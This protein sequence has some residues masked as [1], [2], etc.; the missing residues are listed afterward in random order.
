[1]EGR[2]FVMPRQKRSTYLSVLL[3]SLAVVLTGCLDDPTVVYR[4]RDLFEEPPAGAADFLGYSNVE[5]KRTVCG[6][7]HTGKQRDWAQTAHAGAWG[8]LQAAT[9]K[10]PVCQAC[11][12]V[13]SR[14]NF[15]TAENAGFVGTQNVR[16]TDVQ[17][18]SCHGPG[19]LHVTDPDVKAN[20]PL[21]PLAVGVDLTRG[22][23][24]CHS[25]VHRP[26]AEE[27]QSSRHANIRPAQAGNA[28]CRECHEGRAFLANAGI[29]VNFIEKTDAAFMPT[30][31]GVCHDPHSAQNDGQLRFPIDVP[32]VDRNL[33]MMCHHKR[34]E[35]DLTQAQFRGPHSP[36]G[37][38]LVGEA[39]W[40]PPGFNYP[41]GSIV[42]THGSERNPR[43][44]AGCHVNDYQ[45][46][47]ALTG[48]F[49]FRATGHSFQAIPCVDATG[50]PTGSRTCDISQRS[51]RSCTTCHGSE[52]AA[53]SALITAR[54]RLDFL[55][56]SIQPLIAR[57]PA[58]EMVHV[59]GKPFT[60]GQGARF[61]M[62][63]A[64]MKGSE[65]HNPFLVESL[66][67]ASIRQ[68]ETTYGIRASL[69]PAELRPQLT[70]H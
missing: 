50:K 31:C 18:E 46:S 38:L 65:V 10:A 56:N 27:W 68:L 36:E 41:K 8:T 2:V 24:Q 64:R 53:R 39:G 61:N 49:Q 9:A 47:D 6:N 35:P 43:L 22:C 23:G 58:S 13:S 28:A 55:V 42:G 45:V 11:H 44:C 54:G 69:Q 17:C 32:D 1:M 59:S 66:L 5:T 26:F 7:C 37:P 14:G 4:D 16:Y 20:R 62:E 48:S 3:L 63:L 21:A 60:A 70:A 51:F 15:T 25:G 29:N 33:C 12:S 52:A 40:W 57:V 34:G 19:L 67:L 30:T